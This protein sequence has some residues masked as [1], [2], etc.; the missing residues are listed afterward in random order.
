ME[1]FCERLISD[2]LCLQGFCGWFLVKYDRFLMPAVPSIGV[3]HYDDKYYA[4]SS[5]EAAYEFAADPVK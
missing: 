1:S 4:F 5:K 3:L 2:Y